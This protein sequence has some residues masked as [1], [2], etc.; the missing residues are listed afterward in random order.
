MINSRIN[1]WIGR[2]VQPHS[3]MEIIQWREVLVEGRFGIAISPWKES[4]GY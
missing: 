4:N 2:E 3:A 1:E